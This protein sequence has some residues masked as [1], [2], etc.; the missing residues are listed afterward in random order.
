MHRFAAVQ[1]EFSWMQ[2]S[3]KGTTIF[4]NCL[5]IRVHG[6]TAEELIPAEPQNSL[7]GRI[8]LNNSAVRAVIY[9]SERN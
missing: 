6:G 9:H 8:R 7:G 1:N 3:G 5:P 4:V 2:L